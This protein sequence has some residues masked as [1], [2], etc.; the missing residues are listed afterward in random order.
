MAPPFT[1]TTIDG[2]HVSMDD[3]QGKVVLVDFWATWCAPCREALPSIREI[4][5]KF[6]VNRW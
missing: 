4:A 2:N 5:K 6:R 1:V 3:L